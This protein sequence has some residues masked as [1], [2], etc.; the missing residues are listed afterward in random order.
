MN[1]HLVCILAVVGLSPAVLCG[2]AMASGLPSASIFDTFPTGA[3][4]AIVEGTV[5]AAGQATT[6]DLEYDVASSP[7]CSS[8]GATGSAANVTASQPLGFTDATDHDV[9]ITT[10]G[11]VTGT[12]YCG[13][14]VATNVSGTFD[15]TIMPS[16]FDASPVESTVTPVTADSA[17]AVPC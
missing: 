2:T 3:T 15:S 9:S 13:R 5:N 12:A 14:I 16:F 10:T 6:Y 1:R 17:T 4:T 8:D 7:W 11:L